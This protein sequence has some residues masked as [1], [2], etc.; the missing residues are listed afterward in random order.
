MSSASADAPSAASARLAAAGLTATTILLL[1]AGLS[2]LRLAS[3]AI[4]FTLVRK[5]SDIAAHG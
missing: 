2:M 1:T 5:D 3:A 4:A